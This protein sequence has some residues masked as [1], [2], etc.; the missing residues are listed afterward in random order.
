L[1]ADRERIQGELNA[2]AA[3]CARIDEELLE[4][5]SERKA[6][7][8]SRPPLAHKVAKDLLAHYE[9]VRKVRTPAVVPL[10]DETC[11]G[12]FMVVRPQ[13]VNEIM[14]NDKVH[15]CQHCGRL[16]YYPGNIT[17]HDEASVAESV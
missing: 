12:C 1:D 14:A 8:K 10:K 6:L 5:T 3:E 17:G 7:V 2:I 11:G 15:A 16:L 4:L 9:R 13:I